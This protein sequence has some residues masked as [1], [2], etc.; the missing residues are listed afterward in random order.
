[1]RISDWSSD[2]CSSDLIIT[3]AGVINA[4]YLTNRDLKDVKVVV[5]GAGAAAIACTELIKAM[6]VR[7]DNVIMCDRKGVIYQGR[8][9]GMDQW[10]SAH[11][12]KTSARTLED[13]LK[14][15]DIFLGLSAADA[16]KP[17]MVRD[18]AAKP[19]IFRSEERRVGNEGVSRC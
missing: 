19:I 15:A 8:P 13:A 10:K 5:N 3:A 17:E 11:A 9:E 14:G 4:C 12:A 7:S 18:M 16:V 6:G 2:V 1:M